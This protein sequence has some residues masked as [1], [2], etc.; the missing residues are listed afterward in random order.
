MSS[1][2]ATPQPYDAW[3]VASLFLGLSEEELAWLALRVG[4]R[5][6]APGDTLVEEGADAR[7]LFV[8]Q[9]GKLEV[10]K[11][12]KL[13]FRRHRIHTL[14]HGATVGEVALLERGPRSATV[15]AKEAS[16][17]WVLDFLDLQGRATASRESV[18]FDEVAREIYVK[19][20]SNLAA[21]A[22]GK[23]RTGSEDAL[24]RA[25]EKSAMGELIV[26]VL[27]VLC[28]YMLL[29][30]G[31]ESLG[32][33]PRNTMYVSLPVLTLLGIVSWRF[34]VG[35]GFPLEDFGIT[36]RHLW[37]SLAEAAL[38]TLGLVA[39][40]TGIKWV[41]IQTNPAYAG[42]R[43]LQYPDLLSR[44]AQPK[45]QIL[46][47]VYAVSSAVQELIV[48]GAL[49]SMLER[50]LTGKYRRLRAV[51]VCT[52]LFSV[53]HLHT[54]LLFTLA[55]LIPGFCWGLLFTRNRNLIGVTLSHVVIGVYVFFVLGV[56]L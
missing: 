40:A 12:E 42:A 25:H 16:S 43:L 9:S 17:V 14:G 31:L 35:S 45:I 8:V 56:R 36:K 39:V 11:R 3:R 13:G 37:G 47:G 6:L 32:L 38:F 51:G 46:S 19:L 55:V 5:A 7:H 50:F 28:V 30:S 1:S 27:I 48:R 20:T 33:K 29:I 54:G 53:S 22:A 41:L 23:V 49:Q 52:L 2:P 44:F 4:V 10:L 24:H 15:R 18:D 34:M 21:I 26:N